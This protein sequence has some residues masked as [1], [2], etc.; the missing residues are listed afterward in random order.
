MKIFEFESIE[1]SYSVLLESLLNEG[2]EVSPRGYLTKEI[3]PIAI[4]INNPRKRVIPSAVRKLN[5]GF[6]CAELIWILNG[7]NDVNFI[8]HY[9]SIWKQFTD[10]GETLNGAYGKR[11]FNWDSGIRQINSENNEQQF[12]NVIIN[13]FEQAYKQL[14]AD[15]NTRQATIVFFDPYLDY[16]E[17]K[18]KPCTNLIRFMIRDNKLNMTTFMRSNDIIK[19]Y[20]YDVFNFTLLQEIMA[21]MLEIEVGKYVHIADSFHLYET[22][23]ELAKNIIN[24]SYP[25][26]YGK[27]MDARIM[28]EDVQTIFSKVFNIENQ[29]RTTSDLD[30]NVVINLINDIGHEYWK[31]ISALLATYN[32]RKH[33]RTQEELDILKEYITNEFR[34]LMK[35][36]YNKLN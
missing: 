22:D 7:S 32:F 5:F 26:L 19:G 33:R 8:G 23:F 21:G 17:T 6:M 9:N 1:E 10:D 30:I 24:E 2:K 14:K 13:Q 29:T 15:P 3:N 28:P 35:E 12:E 16:R 18:D 36:R 20:P 31:S 4:T 11:I 27:T 34:D 25:L